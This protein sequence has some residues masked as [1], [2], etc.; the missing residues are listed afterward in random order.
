MVV[1]AD[2]HTVDA[3]RGIRKQVE[4]LRLQQAALVGR[5][6]ITPA[7]ARI[8]QILARLDSIEAREN[9]L[10]QAILSTPEKALALPLMRRDLDG[11]KETNAQAIAAVK[12][13]VDQVYDLTKW[14]IGALAVGVFSL[15]IPTL[16]TW[17]RS[18]T[19][20]A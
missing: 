4:Q 11:A 17:R 8:V 5:D 19:V 13:S 3:I 6:T 1:A 2:D 16:I 14:F 12:A 15:A 7:D 10:E 18:E 20:S 9:R